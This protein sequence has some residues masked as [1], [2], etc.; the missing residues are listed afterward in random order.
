MAENVFF[1]GHHVELVNP[2]TLLETIRGL[3]WLHPTANAIQVASTQ[4]KFDKTEAAAVK[5]LNESN[6]FR[7]VV[8]G[9]LMVNLSNAC[10]VKRASFVMTL[11]S[12]LV[13]ANAYGADLVIH[14]GKHLKKMTTK[15]ALD[16]YVGEV[17][18]LCSFM[19][20]NGL[21]NHL[22]LENAAGQG[23]EVGY[24][25]EDLAYIWSSL[26][27]EAKPFTGFCIDTCHLF[28]SGE[29]NVSEPGLVAL[30]FDRLGTHVGKENV[31]L[32]HLNGSK[33]GLG[34]R[35]DR[36]APLTHDSCIDKAGIAAVVKVA[37]SWGTTVIMETRNF[38]IGEELEFCNNV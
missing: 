17:E 10:P 8:H 19:K 27:A 3:H 2:A 33:E 4:L 22:L 6:Q 30:W 35:K 7:T 9:N 28:A 20:E 5:E 38:D 24:S 23:T 34:S 36:H 1:K 14:Q 26:S 18:A 15:E 11:K 12:E 16:T 37:Q 25:V 29:L 32:I 31:R 21:T 13:V